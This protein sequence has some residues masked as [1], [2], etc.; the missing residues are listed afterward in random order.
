VQSLVNVTLKRVCN[1]RVRRRIWGG[2]QGRVEADSPTPE[3]TKPSC[4]YEGFVLY[5]ACTR[6][7]VAFGEARFPSGL[8]VGG[9]FGVPQ[10]KT[11]NKSASYGFQWNRIGDLCCI[12]IATNSTISI[13]VFIKTIFL[14]KFGLRRSMI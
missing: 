8:E 12:I 7:T 4:F 6:R 3:T 13:F 14:L 10:L 11:I 5:G 2:Y 9:K 1:G